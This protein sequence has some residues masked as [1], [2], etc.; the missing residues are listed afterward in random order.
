[1]TSCLSL[2]REI[3]M[4]PTFLNT[5]DRKLANKIIDIM[6]NDLDKRA[7]CR[8]VRIDSNMAEV[9]IKIRACINYTD[10]QRAIDEEKI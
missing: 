4:K 8:G 2:Q 7:L 6:E 9:L 10:L 5:S 1:M 3:V